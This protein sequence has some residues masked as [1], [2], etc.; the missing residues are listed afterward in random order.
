M[1]WEQ[2]LGIGSFV[3]SLVVA[4][5]GFRKTKAEVSNLDADTFTKYQEALRKAQEN[6]DKS[7]EGFQL[8]INDLK[9]KVSQLE[10]SNRDLNI[11]NRALVRQLITEA[12]LTPITLEQAKKE[13]GD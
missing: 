2:F 13:V 5:F 12:K 8:D 9:Q 7:A 10:S 11:H 1:S 3:I 6:Y 4:F